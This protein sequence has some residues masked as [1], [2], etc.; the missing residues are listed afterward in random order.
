MEVREI[1]IAIPRYRR[2]WQSFMEIN[3]ITE[4]S[5][6]EVNSIEKTFLWEEDGDRAA[7]G[8]IAGNVIKYV[9]VCSKYKEGGALFNKV[10]SYLL[11]QA[12]QM[13]RFHLFVFTKPKY[14]QSFEYV[15]FKKLAV[16]DTGAIL[17]TGVPGVTEYIDKLPHFEGKIG[18]IVMN[19]N[20]FTL[21][22]RRLVEVAS[23][24]ND[25]VY[26][27]VVKND[28]SLF[29]Y[30]ERIELVKQ[31]VQDLSNVTVVSGNDYIISPATFP[32]YF[33]KSDQEIGTYQARLDAIL[34]KNQIAK[35]LGIA[36][37]YLGKEPYSKTTDSY[38]HELLDILPPEV[39]VEI[40][41]RKTADDKIISATKVRQAILDD[42]QE[43]LH[44]FLPETTMEFV[45]DNYPN[46]K[47]RLIEKGSK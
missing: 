44:E 45:K 34:F 23:S 38:N 22:H 18:S 33:L 43:L 2:K 20:P 9:A 42:D 4:F 16:S 11:Q 10:V 21:G 30:S 46:L 28:V 14:V 36:T 13:G 41:D 31:G 40:I 32:A 47:E 8:S 7:T 24:K 26:V 37:R 29:T 25:H 35:P 6:N 17:E 3:G 12:A 27:F 15:G 5:P 1:N 39:N 19:A